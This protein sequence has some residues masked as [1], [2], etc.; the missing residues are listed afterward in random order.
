[1]AKPKGEALVRNAADEEQVETATK[2]V[3]ERNALE[4][5]DYRFFLG[6][7]QGRRVFWRILRRCGVQRTPYA[8][9][10]THATAFHCGEQNIGL[11]LSATAEQHAPELARQ[12]REEA[13][14]L[15]EN[16]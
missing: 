15:Q 12:M 7:P 14:Q 5:A 4:R 9:E 16:V 3:G 13:A 10:L 6:T 1:M 8:G 11:E 2:T